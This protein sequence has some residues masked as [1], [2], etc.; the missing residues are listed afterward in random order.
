VPDGG[1]HRPPVSGA[2]HATAALVVEIRSPDDESR[3]KLP[4]YAEHHV[5]EVLIV[6][7]AEQT[8]MWLALR[9]GGYAPIRRSGLIELGPGELAERS[10]WPGQP[11]PGL[12]RPDS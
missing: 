4:F 10:D 9:D 5:D 11:E 7:P 6:D 8:V 2:W 3:Q 1:L 12:T